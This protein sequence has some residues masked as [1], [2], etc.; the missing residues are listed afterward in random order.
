MGRQAANV[1]YVPAMVAVVVGM[2]VLFFR[3]HFWEPATT[4]AAK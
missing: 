3:D 4:H 1:V 2:D